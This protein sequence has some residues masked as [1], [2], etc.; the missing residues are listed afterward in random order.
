MGAGAGIP[1]SKDKFL[2]SP[3]LVAEYAADSTKRFLQDESSDILTTQLAWVDDS[4]TI[5]ITYTNS[6]NCN[7]DGSADEDDY[8]PYGI[9]GN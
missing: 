9:N 5:A 4:Y 7:I 2:T 1:W 3:L 6:D 8:F